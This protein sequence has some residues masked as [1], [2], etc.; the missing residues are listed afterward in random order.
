MK[1]M[2]DVKKSSEDTVWMLSISVGA[3][4]IFYTLMRFLRQGFKGKTKRL[5]IYGVRIVIA[6]VTA[7]LPM[8]LPLDEWESY[9]TILPFTFIT[10]IFVVIDMRQHFS[11]VK[12]VEHTERVRVKTIYEETGHLPE[13]YRKSVA[14]PSTLT[15]EMPESK[16]SSSSP[17]ADSKK[18]G[19]NIW[20]KLGSYASKDS[21]SSNGQP[22]SEPQYSYTH[23]N[24]LA[25]IEE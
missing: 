24:P 4:L 8:F 9:W 3:V 22:A 6:V 15:I 12:K 11:I 7:I 19:G 13:R 1:Y 23:E 17:S 21:S 5:V 14:L 10:S 2:F 20:S 25:S 16:K 18:S